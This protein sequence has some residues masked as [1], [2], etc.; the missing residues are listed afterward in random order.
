MDESK[1]IYAKEIW[2]SER[3]S[4]VSECEKQRNARLNQRQ[5]KNQEKRCWNV[6]LRCLEA[7]RAKSVHLGGYEG[8]WV[9]SVDFF[10]NW[11]SRFVLRCPGCLLK[12]PGAVCERL[13]RFRMVF[14]GM[15]PE[16]GLVLTVIWRLLVTYS[17]VA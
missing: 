11:G 14:G 16:M 2:Q 3:K 1:M 9:K 13:Q 17:E 8:D 6:E 7:V 12:V 5:R 4:R 10:R 15:G